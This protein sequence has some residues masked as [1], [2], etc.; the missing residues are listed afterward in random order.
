MCENTFPDAAN[1]LL[2]ADISGLANEFEDFC[3]RQDNII[4]ENG[5]NVNTDRAQCANFLKK[6]TYKEWIYRTAYGQAKW[7]DKA[8]DNIT[9]YYDLYSV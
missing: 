6:F 9:R 7:E 3:K 2:D 1:I 4:I 5:G 8:R